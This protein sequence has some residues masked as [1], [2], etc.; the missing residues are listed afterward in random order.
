MCSTR[1]LVMIERVKVRVKE[2]DDNQIR[3]KSI[4]KINMEPVSIA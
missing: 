2:K 3:A 1:N 4:T